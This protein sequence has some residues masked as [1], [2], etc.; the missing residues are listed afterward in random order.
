MAY[1]SL[2]EALSRVGVT[3]SEAERQI[4]LAA[5]QG[6]KDTGQTTVTSSTGGGSSSTV[7][8]TTRPPIF[9]PP[10]VNPLQQQQDLLNQYLQQQQ[11]A[12]SARINSARD[13]KLSGLKDQQ[14]VIGNQYTEAFGRLNQA[15]QQAPRQFQQQRTQADMQGAQ[16]AQRLR[17]L[18][19]ARGL[20]A[21]GE[22][23]TAN[24]GLQNQLQGTMGAIG[25]QEQDYMTGID[26]QEQTLSREQI[27]AINQILNQMNQVRNASSAEEIASVNE[28]AAQGS[29]G[30]L[31][32]FN[33]NADRDLQVQ[34]IGL[35]QFNSFAKNKLEQEQLLWDQNQNNPAVQKQL[36]SNKLLELE[37][38]GFPERQQLEIA[39]L[40]RDANQPYITT[41]EL[42]R[43]NAQ[44]DLYRAQAENVGKEQTKPTNIDEAI[45]PYQSQLEK[46]RSSARAGDTS[47]MLNY[48]LSLERNGIPEDQIDRL[49]IIN[50][51]PLGK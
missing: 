44:A 9:Q 36:L 22:N 21:G 46:L 39:K 15:R 8:G 35:D 49:L 25:Q 13:I 23:I 29:K 5:S 32:L 1:E 12:L 11:A 30:M 45:K 38:E 48:I 41:A 47:G 16:S 18:M 7:S 17:E 42:N 14:G 50:G 3:G 40:R 28:L 20:G 19:A 37:L 34:R 4:S 2:R 24:V 26:Q 31:D 27:T 51:L 6:A 43:I 10:P 33:Q